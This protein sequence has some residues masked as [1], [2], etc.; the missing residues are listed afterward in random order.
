MC[1]SIT[2]YAYLKGY[3]VTKEGK[4]IGLKGNERSLN[5]CSNG[6]LNATIRNGKNSCSRLWVH[7]LQAYQKFGE[8]TLIDGIVV[9]HFDGNPLNNEWDNILIGT[10]SDNMMDIPKKERILNASNPSHNHKAILEDRKN[11]MTYKEIMSKHSISSK[12]T[13]SFIINKSLKTKGLLGYGL[14]FLPVT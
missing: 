7:K 14:S 3:R 4:L 2:K 1:S 8:K 6:Y 13:V 11:G 5:L 9:R 10:Q 12:A